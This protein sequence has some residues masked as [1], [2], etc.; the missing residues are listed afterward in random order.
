[1]L[2]YTLGAVVAVI[3]A[4]ALDVA[5]TRQRLVTHGHFWVA[6]AVI[7][8]FQLVMNGVLTGIPIVTYDPDVHLG[9]RVANAPVED[10]GFGFG[11]VLSVLTVW[12]RAG[13]HPGD[14]AAGEERG[15]EP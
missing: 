8:F 3:A 12:S 6:Y 2:G 5:G 11:L 7:L 9:L 10:I 13:A 4:V 1:M 15:G 14:D